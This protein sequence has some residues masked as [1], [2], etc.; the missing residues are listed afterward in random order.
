MSWVYVVM[1]AMMANI[2]GWSIL[3]MVRTPFREWDRLTVS[4]VA[5][6]WAVAALIAVVMPGGWQRLADTPPWFLYPVAVA[7]GL[8]VLGTPVIYG[9]VWRAI[10]D[11]RQEV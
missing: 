8:S 4:I 11:R 6:G 5:T 7:M 10:R 9:N 1:I 2:F 3:E